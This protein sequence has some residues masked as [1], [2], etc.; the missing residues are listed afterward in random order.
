VNPAAH[1]LRLAQ[2]APARVLACGAYLKNRAC[3]LDGDQVH[4]S[5]VHGDLSDADSR[6]A[7][8]QSVDDL[9]AAA[10]G[11]V[12]AVAHD[13]HPDFFS[14][15]LAIALA[16]QHQVPAVAVQH[17]HAHVAVVQAERGLR[18]TCI[19]IALDGMGL[20][21]DGSAW[22]GEVL[23]VA[24]QGAQWRRLGSLVPLAQP[25]GDAA[26]REPWRLAAAV[27][28]RLGRAD[29]IVSLWGP[30]V[31]MSAATMVQ[32]LL[33]RD[34][35]CPRSSSAGRWFDAAAGALGVSVRQPT[36]AAAAMALEALATDWLAQY[37]LVEP[38]STFSLDLAP[39]VGIYFAL[40]GQGDAALGRAAAGFHQA[41][42]GALAQAAG[43]QA[44]A[45]GCDA[46]VLAGGCMANR[47]LVRLLSRDLRQAGLQVVTAQAAG[48]GDAGLALGQAWVAAATLP[49]AVF[50]PAGQTLVLEH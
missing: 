40:R 44:R 2:P 48:C 25:G 23:W 18:G 34:L 26:A 16:H 28:H 10:H 39:L 29:E 31:G 17:H 35:Q 5:A 22:G 36:E 13:M 7:L 42:A 12:A 11:P 1:T 37:E 49:Q 30:L 47:L 41:M 20:G 4:W 8:Q 24:A 14:T 32:T 21:T 3:L 46:V 6:D 33:A 50:A 45:L 27:L 38:A 19:G 15:R 9:L 43:W